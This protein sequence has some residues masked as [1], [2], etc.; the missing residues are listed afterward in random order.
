MFS[1]I[2]QSD[3]MRASGTI[4]QELVFCSTWNLGWDVKYQNNSPFGQLLGESNTKI[5]KKIKLELFSLKYE[6]K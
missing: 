1:G 3:R 6:Q 2:L 4:T 5:S